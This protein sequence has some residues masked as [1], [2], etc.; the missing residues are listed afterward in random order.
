MLG[1]QQL[2][3]AVRQPSRGVLQAIGVVPAGP[4]IKI[5]HRRAQTGLVH[6]RDFF[7]FRMR[8]DLAVIRRDIR[9][10]ATAVEQ[11]PVGLAIRS[12]AV[13]D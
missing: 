2:I 11:I 3:A 7:Q 10:T 8:G 5:T 12:Y 9:T 1:G 4:A 6:H 13:A